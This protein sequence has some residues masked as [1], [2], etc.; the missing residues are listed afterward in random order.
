MWW[1]RHAGGPATHEAGHN[2]IIQ[3]VKW[4]IRKNCI[5]HRYSRRFLNKKTPKPNLYP[6]YWMCFVLKYEKL[7][8]WWDHHYESCILRWPKYHQVYRCYQHI[9]NTI[10]TWGCNKQFVKIWLIYLHHWVYCNS[11]VSGTVSW[12]T[13]YYNIAIY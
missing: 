8:N 7:E 5:I 9:N 3:G 11:L 1:T 10:K 13:L 6:H 2:L 4:P 12:D